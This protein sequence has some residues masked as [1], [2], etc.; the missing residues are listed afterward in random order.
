MNTNLPQKNF[1]YFDFMMAGF[2]TVLLCSNLIGA[3]KVAQVNNF[4]FGAAVLFF[5]ISYVFGDVMT[6]VYGYAK[7]RRVI[8]AGFVAMIFASLMSWIVVAMPPSG[9]W[10]NQ[11]ALETVFGSTIRITIGSLIAFWSGEFVNSYILARLKVKTQGKHL[12]MRTIGSTLGGE[13]VD[14]LIF[15][16]IAFWGTWSDGLLVKVM[17]TNA[18]LKISWEVLM[19]P[20]TYKLVA[21]L[22][23]HEHEDHYDRRTNFNPFKL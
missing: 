14:S 18:F 23:K 1:K 19:T 12:W 8:W 10:P 11:A 2:V 21:F 5:P 15:Y 20:I 16:P 9:N 22:K 17:I 3:A 7:A 4:E 6:E 13:F